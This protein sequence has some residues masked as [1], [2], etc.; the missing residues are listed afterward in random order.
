MI[1]T[2]QTRRSTTQPL[3]QMTDRISALAVDSMADALEPS[4]AVTIRTTAAATPLAQM[5]QM[6]W[7]DVFRYQEGCTDLLMTA[8]LEDQ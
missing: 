2:N 5:P 4:T 1:Q 7:G 6:T 8:A 3:R